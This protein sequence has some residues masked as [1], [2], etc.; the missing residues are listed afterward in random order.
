MAKTIQ[1]RLGSILDTVESRWSLGLHG[2]T[3]ITVVGATAWGTWAASI[4]SQY[5]PLS[6]IAAGIAGAAVWTVIRLVWVWGYKIKIRAQYDAKFI[7]HGGTF[8]PLDLTFERQRIYLNDFALPSFPLIEGKTFIECEIIG[9][10]IVYFKSSN[11]AVPIK[12][13]KVDA[14][15]L[16]PTAQMANHFT[17][18]NCIFRNCSFQRITLFAS[19]E[20]FYLWKDNPNINWL[21]I[22]PSQTD[23]D[24]RHKVINELQRKDGVP[25]SPPITPPVNNADVA[26]ET[27]AA[28][29]LLENGSHEISSH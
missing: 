1:E 8:N 2:V 6:W 9:P 10:A 4:F 14:V 19:I 23:L 5:A 18:D 13:P 28:P 24:E 16:N 20:N 21:S 25:L 11:L 12:P 17:F 3:L 27:P 7:E 29:L 26:S 22:A 15:W